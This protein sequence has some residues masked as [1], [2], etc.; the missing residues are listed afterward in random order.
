M[1]KLVLVVDDSIV[2]RKMVSQALKSKGFEVID[3][4]N[5]K[6]ALAK[7]KG[8]VL[9]LIITDVN[10]PI[11]SGMELIQA[12]RQE[13]SHR[14]TPIVV[15]T[16]ESGDMRETARQAGATAWVVK[17]FNPEKLLTVV[18]QLVA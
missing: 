9:S 12:L 3:A 8:V 16:T 6:D 11:M 5:G 14:F 1:P 7:A 15:L 17:P 4:A 2:M 13:G 10:M 18:Q